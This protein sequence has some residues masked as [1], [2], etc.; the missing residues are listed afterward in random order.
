M[1]RWANLL[2]DHLS[3]QATACVHGVDE[4]LRY[5]EAAVHG[6]LSGYTEEQFDEPASG[7]VELA[8]QRE[9]R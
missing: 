3:Q 4:P 9:G 5:L 6:T 7:I 2:V 1:K 8:R